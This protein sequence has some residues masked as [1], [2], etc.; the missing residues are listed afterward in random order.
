MP[1]K[2]YKSITVRKE[3]YD[4]FKQI[5]DAREAELS[6]QGITS[7]SAFCTKLLNDLMREEDQR[8]P[9]G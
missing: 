6:L 2:K 8:N 5:Y 7:F 1:R 9:P 4:Y 3:V